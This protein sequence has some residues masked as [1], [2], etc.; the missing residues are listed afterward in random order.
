MSKSAREHVE[1]IRRD[2]YFIGREEKNPLA[3]DMHHAVNYL[4]DELYSKDVHFLMELIQ[5]AEDN[6]YPSGVAPSLEFVITS[7]DITGTGAASTLLVFNNE[8][9]FSESN[10]ESICRVGK[11]TKKGQ[12]HRGYIG[13]KGI[14]FKS[15]F[16]ISNQPHIFSNGYQIKFNEEPSP[17]CGLGYIVPEWV[18][19]N[20]TPTDL[21]DIYGASKTLPT[22]TIILPL[23]P[24]KVDPVKRQLSSIHPEILLFLSKI[25]NLSVREV[26]TN[27]RA[28]S[29]VTQISIS[30]EKD[31]Q[32]RKIV[33]AESFS[34]HL[35]AQETSQ[36]GEDQCAYYMWKQKFPVKRECRVKKREEV[37]EWVITLAFP[38]GERL[39]RG[40]TSS[41]VYAFL[42][43]EMVTNF[44][45]IIQADFLLSS[46]RETILLDSPWN[47][48]ILDCVP[49]AFM[50][51]FVSLV[52]PTSDAPAF[53][54]PPK[55]RFLPVKECSI[56]LLD[57][58]R[59]SIKNK[60]GG[61]A[62]IPCES[63]TPQKIFCKP[64]E[65]R[66]LIPAF[67]DL[68]INA[69]KCG[70]DLQSISSHGTCILSSYFDTGDYNDVLEFL[71][72]GYVDSSWYPKCIEGSNLVK[73]ASEEVY[74]QLLCF[75]SDNWQNH[76][77]NN[78]KI[79]HVP[80]LKYENSNGALSFSS[81][82]SVARGM[83]ILCIASEKCHMS[84]LISSNREFASTSSRCFL[85]SGTQEELKG[86][87]KKSIV[88]DW[89]QSKVKLE[90]LDT[91]RYAGV[92][93]K[94][95]SG[96]QQAISF[97]HFLYHS[98]VKGHIEERRIMDLCNDMPVVDNYGV[99][100]TQRSQL[101]V[102]AK[103][104]KWV[105]LMGS[106]PW[107]GEKYIELSAEYEN[108]GFFA[109]NYAAQNELLDF[110]KTY[111]GASDVP[112][113]NPPNASFP[114]VSSGLTK[115][116]ALLILQWIRNLS[117]KGVRLPERFLGCVKN[118]SWIKTSIGNKPPNECFLS[119]AE[120]GS[121]L[122]IGSD[123]VD[124]PMIDH[125]FYGG[126]MSDFKEELKKIGVKFEFGEASEFIGHH[127][128]SIAAERSLTRSNV[129][130]LLKLIRFL[131]EKHL[132]PSHL[133][134]SINK[135]Q[136]LKT[137]KGYKTPS[138]TILFDSEWESAS[139][140]SSLPFIDTNF[141]GQC[142]CDYKTELELLGVVVGFKNNHK[143]V[144]DNFEFRASVVTAEAV[145]LLLECVRYVNISENLIH[146]IKQAKWVNTSI[147]I[148]APSE[149]FL[150]DPEWSCLLNAIEGVPFIDLGYYGN[151]MLSWKE[152]LGRIGVVVRF[153]DA[154]KAIAEKFK[155]IIPY[156][157]CEKN[158]LL[159]LDSY[160]QLKSKADFLPIVTCMREENW[161]RTDMG[162]KAPKN[163]ILFDLVWEP[164]C[165]VA[166]LPFIDRAS[167][168]SEYKDELKDL[169]V[170]VGIEQGAKFV[171]SGLNIPSDAKVLTAST[172]LSLL[173][174]IK[175][176]K[177]KSTLPE[178]FISNIRKK[179]LKTVMGY[180]YP[181][182]SILFDLKQFSP[183]LRT[184]GPFIDEEFYGPKIVEYN[185][186]LAE[187]GVKVDT[188]SARSLIA[189]KL[190]LHFDTST[191]SRIYAFLKE[192]EWK[193][194]N[195]DSDFIWIPSGDNNGQ[196]V[197]PGSCVVH[198]KDGLFG[199][200]LHVLEKYY[201][202]S[203]RSFFSSAFNVKYG[204]CVED[205]CKLWKHWE[206]QGS[207]CLVSFSDCTA[208]WEFIR[209]HWSTKS[210]KLISE[211]VTKLPI[212]MK[213]GIS[214][215]SKGDVFIPDDLVLKDLFEESLFVWYPPKTP[216]RANLT[217]IYMQIGARKISESVEKHETS[218]LETRA[219]FTTA[220][221]KSAIIQ[222]GLLKI[223]LA[224][225]ADPCLDIC[226]K[227][228]HETVTPLLNLTIFGT[229]E[230]IT[231]NYILD[232]SSVNATQMAMARWERE[233]KI[234]YIQRVDGS[235]GMECK[236]KFATYFAS[237]MAQ[238]L[239]Y[240]RPDLI[241]S[242]VEIIKL[243][244]LLEFEEGAIGFLLKT[245]NLQLFVEDEEF[246]SSHL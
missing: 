13:E 180:R 43:T 30:S 4:S 92:V 1:R 203:L 197:N 155:Q 7:K 205:Y 26:N 9:G 73:E 38:H 117:Y 107:R 194:E 19:Q 178:G 120:W 103:G 236:I 90:V 147:G 124:I 105:E 15:V 246:L 230:P 64:G 45:F 128:M 23:K 192:S 77:S 110:M 135:D 34:L 226:V 235:K 195:Q 200:Q 166:S 74:L 18:D 55:F 112:Y 206:G 29:T 243:A 31:Y 221:E 14:G 186:E 222:L 80:L 122:Q 115:K 129:L 163:S 67:W 185:Q 125:E 85:P 33:D 46:S 54:L 237:E 24:D 143:L 58:V 21:I 134:G 20:P 204:P 89:F 172:V 81:I 146:R 140:I 48:G 113:I 168:I 16:L 17:D 87:S 36:R 111:L 104:S 188:S 153:D 190:K 11:S 179:W 126:K 234:L 231:L 51:A 215:S 91:Y 165:S 199:S 240:E 142:I 223:S 121:L 157:L 32:A 100:V 70:V 189:E 83:I 71:G 176:F 98:L 22:T 72:V 214:L 6:E 118:G 69:Q 12:R 182:E 57:S 93:S 106:N 5:N 133:V 49:S 3:E 202:P 156:S 193:L 183:V 164:L 227:E 212:S 136:W 174:C 59:L 65:A 149:T 97:A 63:Y 162:F 76:F 244:C 224:F 127:L 167:K 173:E 40:L 217:N 196:W 238:G 78:G 213:T 44:P 42:P 50:N 232:Q 56:P 228:R 218:D 27:N 96:R 131:R 88:M 68:L 144:V 109:G 139:M 141:Y 132:S 75:I 130:S 47:K 211:S 37:D 169:G 10:I 191:I 201:G 123:M 233:K 154:S 84:W 138:D 79:K 160:R 53:S 210:Q 187:I 61:E 175:C 148:K 8:K 82:D 28:E 245:R 216:S 95:I 220:G 151:K 161:L 242:L 39:S 159:L 209:T 2:R 145:M 114:T 119:S 137:C 225:L 86:F 25:R 229:N 208:F 184:D 170:A 177:K 41:S 94:G 52:K 198:D 207:D 62:I 108:S 35:A 102:P 239:L 171:I 219:S 158:V 101:L 241:G 152:E 181:D 66:R 150:P 116:N 60:L 99:V